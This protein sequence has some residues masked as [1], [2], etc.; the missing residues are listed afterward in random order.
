[1]SRPR[2]RGRHNL[3]AAYSVDAV[4]R[5]NTAAE[6]SPEAGGLTSAELGAI[7]KSVQDLYRTRLYPAIAF[8]L[9]RRGQ[10]LLDRAIGHASG[11]APGDPE[12]GPKVQA[13]P[14]TLFNLFSA[15]KA[16]TAMVVHWLDEQGKVH[17]DDRVVETIPE[18]GRH[19]KEWVTLRH[20]L[21]H[22]AGIPAV[23]M[24][25]DFDTGLFGRGEEIVERLC[26]AKPSFRA[27]RRLA[28]HA[29]TGGYVIGE[30]V[31]RVTGKSIREVLV[32]NIAR[33]LGF[34]HLSYGVS[35]ADLPRV[36]QNA[37]TGPV[38]PRPLA[39][40]LKRSL[41]VPLQ[42]AVEVSNG[43]D[44]LTAV[45]PAGNIV[46][47]ANEGCRFFELLRVGGELDGVRIFEGRTI[48]RAVAEQTYLELDL[49]LGIP[50]RYGLGFML[51]DRVSLY[52]P[53]TQHTFGH[54]GF[55]NIVAMADPQREISAC[56][57]TTGKPL[58][59]LG[60]LRWLRTMRV[61]AR[62]VPRTGPTE[63]GG[64]PGN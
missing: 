16:M 26:D 44:F 54:L 63:V 15:S 42:Q 22:R 64:G 5:I 24:T 17:L 6:A 18:F 23:P 45:I 34:R 60:V 52:G 30:V 1:M 53:H 48:R 13:T 3:I 49:T 61:I 2:V 51:G 38:P 28:Y 21:S 32:E 14:Q 56:L 58:I 25:G 41:G 31:R 62:T 35:L 55:T 12:D 40:V 43:T 8:C 57:I 29:L 27:G 36:A 50:V 59:S 20:I 47:T 9:R 19:G 10:V 7:W 37:F 39:W 33:P 46:S 4:T 11:N